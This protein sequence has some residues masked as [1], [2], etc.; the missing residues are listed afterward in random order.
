MITDRARPVLPFDVTPAQCDNP[1][2][3]SACALRVTGVGV[4]GATG[5][6]LRP[7]L[8]SPCEAA[9]GGDNFVRNGRDD[10][11]EKAAGIVQD[12]VNME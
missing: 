11:A 2:P 5:S 6:T 3:A 4:T 8:S 12:G 1:L 9:S 7:T 10:V